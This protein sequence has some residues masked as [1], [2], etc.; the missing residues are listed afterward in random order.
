[1]GLTIQYSLRSATRY[2]D[3][4][5][6]RVEQ[7]RQRAL[8]LPFQRV[9]DLIDLAG[10]ACDYERRERDDPHRWLLIQAHEPIQREGYVYHVAPTRLFAF[11][12]SPGEGAEPANFGLCRYPR[13]VI[14]HDGR[15]VRT[16]LPSGWYWSSFCKTQYASNPSLGG[17]QQFLRCHLAVIRMLDH[18][19]YLNVL[20]EVC[21]EG[22]Y[23]DGRDVKALVEEVAEWNSMIAGFVGQMTD[24]IGE[25]RREAMSEI[26]KFPNFENLEAKG[27]ADDGLVG[28]SHRST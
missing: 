10:E 2:N 15:R 12:T 25:D 11:S 1:M 22:G 17:T 18:A 8:D 26:A 3:D 13:F 16:G 7:L 14:G 23:W 21:D 5:R 9:G 4:A 28:G 27:R 20:H 6:Q 24:Q 19:R